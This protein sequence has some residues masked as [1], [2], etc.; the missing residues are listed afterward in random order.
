[1]IFLKVP[2]TGYVEVISWL[3]DFNRVVGKYGDQEINHLKYIV[4]IKWFH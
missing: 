3:Q 4:V 2:I 1:V